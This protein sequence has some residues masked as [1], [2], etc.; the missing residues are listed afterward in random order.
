MNQT[1]WEWLMAL[2][3]AR[4]LLDILYEMLCLQIRLAK[5][6]YC[7]HSTIL[8][9]LSRRRIDLFIKIATT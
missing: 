5:Q 6:R 3:R 8:I 2:V 4:L 9:D 1:T 7:L